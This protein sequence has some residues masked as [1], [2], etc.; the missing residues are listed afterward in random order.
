MADS[1]SGVG[2]SSPLASVSTPASAPDSVILAEAMIA[3]NRSAGKGIHYGALLRD[4]DQLIAKDPVLGAQVED[5]VKSQLG[6]NGTKRLMTASYTIG[7]GDK[8]LTMSRAAPSVEQYFRGTAHAKLA[9][10]QAEKTAYAQSDRA[11]YAK[12][13]K[14][15]GDGNA[16][17]FEGAKI[18]KGIGDMLRRGFTLDQAAQYK[19]VLAAEAKAAAQTE[20]LVADLG[21]MALDVIG[22]FDPT[23][24]AD[25]VNAGISAWRGDGW[26]AFLSVISAVPYV[27]DLAKLGKL[28][29][30]A[31]TVAKAVDVAANNPAMRKLVEPSLRKI[32]DL[33]GALPAKAFDAL[34]A[35]AKAAL[36]SMKGKIDDVLGR[37]VDDLPPPRPD[38]VD[39]RPQHYFDTSGKKGAWNDG[40]NAKLT[41]NADYHVNGYKF[42]TD[43]K[44]RVSSVEGQ[45]TLSKAE[46]SGYQQGVAGRADRLPDDEGGHLIASIFNGPGEAVN[47]KAMNG[48]FNRTEFR[49]LERTLEDA[50]KAGKKVE[51]KI[52][53]IHSGDSARPD[54]FAIKYVIDGVKKDAFL[55]NTAGG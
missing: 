26:G 52:D 48:S 49:N 37:K 41:P 8:M 31:K 28:G 13:D 14:M 3:E 25:L 39:G 2:A 30:W 50:L 12:L 34:P 53:V 11:H 1:L 10:T 9:K 21:Q 33:I 23:P 5:A 42:S 4:L 51:V 6:V 16:K 47:L 19:A 40:L 17:T 22:I 7:S 43:A 35:D 36:L 38:V 55:N 54:G 27:G 18:E 44:G 45:L 20:T 46:R 15:F 24:T 32:S 29:N